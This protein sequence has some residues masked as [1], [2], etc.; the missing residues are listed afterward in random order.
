MALTKKVVLKLSYRGHV[1]TNEV[2]SSA[3]L[4]PAKSANVN[5][6][7]VMMN[8]VGVNRAH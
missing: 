7:G 3:L 8:R 5:I 4:V 2:R 6:D 1:G